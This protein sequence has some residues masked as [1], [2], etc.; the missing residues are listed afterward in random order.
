MKKLTSLDEW[1]YGKPILIMVL[2]KSS[3][4]EDSEGFGSTHSWDNSVGHR[5]GAGSQLLVLPWQL[6]FFLPVSSQPSLHPWRWKIHIT[7]SVASLTTWSLAHGSQRLSSFVIFFNIR[8]DFHLDGELLHQNTQVSCLLLQITCCWQ[9]EHPST[10]LLLFLW[11]Q[12]AS[13]VGNHC[14]N[15]THLTVSIFFKEVLYI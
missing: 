7:I 6:I 1:I 2:H 12:A 11:V 8:S 9:A 15:A 5:W 10:Y 14:E 13:C 4:R 3:Q